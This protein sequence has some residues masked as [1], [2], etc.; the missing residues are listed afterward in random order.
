MRF[1]KLGDF[2]DRVR[3]SL[4]LV[5]TN[6]Q[7]GEDEAGELVS[8][9]QAR[10]ADPR[11]LALLPDAERRCALVRFLDQRDLVGKCAHLF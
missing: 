4:H 5:A 9:R 7:Q 11:L 8:H 1:R 10:K 6:L 2:L 3:V